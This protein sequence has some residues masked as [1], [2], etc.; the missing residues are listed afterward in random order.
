ML[1]L[2]FEENRGQA[3]GSVRFFSRGPGYKFYLTRKEMLLELPDAKSAMRNEIDKPSRSTLALRPVGSKSDSQIEGLNMLAGKSNYF[4]GN[5]PRE[6]RTD[7]PHYSH[8]RYREVYSGIDLIYYGNRRQ[9]EYDFVLAPQADP[10]QIKIAFEGAKQIQ[11]DEHGNLLVDIEDRRLLMRKPFIYQEVDG[12]RRAIKGSY[13]VDERSQIRFQ[14]GDYNPD[15]RLVIDPVL[16]FSTYLGGIGTDIGYGIAV[17]QSG[18]IYVTGQ[19]SSPDF[20][21]KNPFNSMINGATDAFVIKLNPSGTALIFSTYIGGRN[22]GDRGW[23]IAVDKA[24]NVYFTGE[25]NSLNFPLV[26]PVQPTFRGNGDA[27]VA[28][29]NIEGDV[30]LYSTYLGG[31]FFDSAYSITL[32]RFDNAYITGRTD[33]NNFPVK[34]ALQAQL[35][36]QRDA[37]VAKLNPDGAL[38]YATYLGG[39]PATTGGLEEESGYGIA[40]DVLQNIYVTG[41]TTS[42]NFPTINAYQPSFGGVEDAFITKINEAGTAIIYSTYLGG[43]RVDNARDIAVDTFGNAYVTGFTVS[44]DF[45]Q[46]NPLQP[47]YGGNIDGFVS[48]LSASGD[49]LVYSTYLGGDGAENNGLLLENITSCAIEVDNFGCAYVTGKT[50]SSNFPLIGAIQTTL[51]GN[52]DAFISKIDPSGSGLIYSTYLGSSFTGDTGFEERGLAIKVDNFGTAYITGQVLASGFPTAQPLQSSYGGGLSDAFIAKIST[53][54]LVTI[55]PVSAASFYGAAHA[56]ESIVAVFGAN[57]AGGI[58]VASGLPLPTTLLGTSVM[59]TDSNGAERPASLF[60]VSPTQINFQ[61]PAGTA[62][63]RT[64]VTVSTGQPTKLSTTI[65]VNNVAPGL[66]SANSNGQGVPAALIFRVKEDGTQSFE[67]VA[68]FNN[69]DRFIPIPIDLGPETDQVF[70]ILFGSGLRNRSSLT[71]IVAHIGGIDVP[72]LFVG[73]VEAFVGE[74]QINLRLPRSLVGRGEVAVSMTVD[75]MIA[76]PVSISIR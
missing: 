75:G 10:G 53:P 57:L 50:E 22:P 72:V 76:N 62:I 55:S 69:Q 40:L 14:I 8:V 24:G 70:L 47:G 34:N 74:D 59:V 4:I 3:D 25:T 56:T 18:N 33:S 46:V 9:L 61:I 11:S 73:A 64:T 63:G 13:L 37:F 29:L 15:Y 21:V 39:E 42:P 12:A 52:H 44:L 41:L 58:D 43:S 31:L 7:I 49:S 35:R 20:P 16:D 2:S 66:F 27:F 26:N 1:P 67:P 65:C 5:N 48:K 19:T 17:D 68:Q 30:L 54:D 28:K 23:A 38:V 60:F 71:N 36:G 32:D 51:Q 45:P 6:W